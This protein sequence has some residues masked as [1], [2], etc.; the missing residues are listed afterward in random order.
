MEQLDVYYRALWDLKKQIGENRDCIAARKSLA[1]AEHKEEAISVKRVICTVEEDWIEAIEQGLVHIEK[2]IKEERQFIRSNGEIV[3]IEKVRHVSKESVQHLA[4]HS[5]MITHVQESEDL[6]PDKLYSVER[7]NDYTVYENRFLYMLLCYLRD[8]ITIRYNKI[9]ELS[10]KYEGSLRLSKEIVLP[11]QTLVYRIDLK[12]ERKDDKYLREHNLAQNVID[13][14]DIILKTVVAFLK[15]PLMEY[16]SKVSMLKP[17]ITKTNVLKMDNNFKGAVA[18]YDFI[19][20]YDK[21]GYSTETKTVEIAPFDADKSAEIADLCA[22]LAFFTYEHGLNLEEGLKYGYEREEQHRQEEK[23]K[24]KKEQLE[25]L[26]KHLANFDGSTEDYILALEK[27]I[28]LLQNEAAQVEPLR[29]V[30]DKLKAHEDELNLTMEQLRCSIDSLNEDIRSCDE[31]YQVI[32]DGVKEEYNERIHSNILKHEEELRNMEATYHTEAEKLHKELRVSKEVWRNEVDSIGSK[33]RESRAAL[34]ELS[35][36]YEKLSQEML[37]TN[38][39]MKAIRVQQGLIGEDEDF[40][41]KDHFDTLEKEF[42]AFFDFYEA[43]WGKTK[44]KIRQKILNYKN[45]KG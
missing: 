39:K 13:R 44:K 4:K 9:L 27:Q 5:D 18:L 32:I 7:L 20:A 21:A 19:M 14:I 2:A 31:R 33:L 28:K 8:F 30:I 1:D 3:P 11:K 35:E 41:E 25:A 40:T 10:N 17:P 22:L 45:L 38:A 36:R 24:R 29:C 43:Q 34:E 6:I 23:I 26:K 12:D 42:D 15:T 16:A 37:V